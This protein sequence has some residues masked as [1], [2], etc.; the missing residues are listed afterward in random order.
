LTRDSEGKTRLTSLLL[1]EERLLEAEYLLKRMARERGEPFGYN[2]NAFLAAARSVTFLLQK[3]YSKIDGF[4]EWWTL[5]QAT[6]AGDSAARFFLELRNY[7]Q[8]EGRIS[9]VGT[10]VARV[11]GRSPWSYRFAGTIKAVPSVLLNRDVVD[12]GREHLA[13]LAQIVLRFGDRF[14]FH[15]CPSRTLTP[16][17]VKMLQ[18]DLDDFDAT[19]GYP[20]GWTNLATG[21]DESERIRCLAGLVDPVDFATIRRIARLKPRRKTTS[22]EN[23]AERLAESMVCALER[24]RDEPEEGHILTDFVA[25]EILSSHKNAND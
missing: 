10:G 13:K 22:N 6:L 4:A 12:C 16:E 1:V 8:K 2:L 11:G 9:I 17:G 25:N 7:S 18:I 5:E 23:L 19:L 3:E 21:E 20:R 24:R 15:S 14:P